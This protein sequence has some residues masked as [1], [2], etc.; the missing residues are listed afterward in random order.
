MDAAR[1]RLAHGDDLLADHPAANH[2]HR[3]H[4]AAIA[5]GRLRHVEFGPP[6]VQ[7]QFR[8]DEQPRTQHGPGIGH[9]RLDAHRT[10]VAGHLRRDVPHRAR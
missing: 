4:V 5:D 6:L 7:L 9:H 10:V 8:R 3:G 1:R 2:E